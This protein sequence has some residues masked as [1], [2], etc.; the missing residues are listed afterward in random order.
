MG[1]SATT[2]LTQEQEDIKHLGDRFPYGDD[3]LYRLYHAYQSIRQSEQSVS[4]LSDLAVHC[5]VLPPREQDDVEK[6]EALREQ[7]AMLMAVVEEKILPPG[8]G[9]R[10]KRV[11]FVKLEY[12]VESASKRMSH[13]GYQ[14][15]KSSLMVQPMEHG[16][17]EEQLLEPCFNV[18]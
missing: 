1:N 8:F 5:T 9:D 18:V 7:Q 10:F 17:E 13:Q 2:S 11:A 3:E 15:W 14:N 12:A 4:F 6:L 16:G